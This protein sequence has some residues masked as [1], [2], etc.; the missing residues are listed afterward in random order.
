MLRGGCSSGLW[1]VQR[2]QEVQS[3]EVRAELMVYVSAH[4]C[5]KHTQKYQPLPIGKHMHA[6][7]HSPLRWL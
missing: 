3:T 4:F 2:L 7:F 5:I 1:A 6:L